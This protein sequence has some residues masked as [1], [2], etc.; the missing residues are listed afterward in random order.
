[1]QQSSKSASLDKLMEHIKQ[2]SKKMFSGEGIDI[3]VYADNVDFKD[4]ITNYDSAEVRETA[5]TNLCK[6]QSLSPRGAQTSALEETHLPSAMP[7]AACSRACVGPR[8]L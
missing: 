4:P 5:S 8:V 3:S 1:M 6:H 2:D 7:M